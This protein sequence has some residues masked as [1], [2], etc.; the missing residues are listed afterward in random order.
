MALLFCVR[1][2]SGV[3]PGSFL[4]DFAAMPSSSGFWDGT[5]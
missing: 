5:E 2:L 3:C 4:Y 1:V